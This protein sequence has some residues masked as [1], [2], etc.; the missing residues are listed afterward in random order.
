[1]ILESRKYKLFINTH[2]NL[3]HFISNE[4]KINETNISLR[5][6]KNLNFSQKM[7]C[8]NKLIENL[9]IIDHY[10]N[11]KKEGL[12]SQ[13]RTILLGFKKCISG[14]FIILKILKNHAIMIN[15][16]SNNV[17][18]VLALKDKFD[19][20]FKTFPVLVDLTILPFENKLI[21]DGFINSYNVFIEKLS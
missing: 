14:K 18:G 21:Y 10:L 20:F 12:T 2:L 11:F 5:E 17:Y 15:T 13:E 6:F 1:M 19:D 9:D 8:R 7:L 16:D 3:L 4:Y